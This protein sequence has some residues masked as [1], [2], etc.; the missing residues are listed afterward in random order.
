MSKENGFNYDDWLNAPREQ[1][2]IPQHARLV[3]DAGFSVFRSVIPEQVQ[4]VFA[5]AA[6]TLG[7]A[8]VE[9]FLRDGTHDKHPSAVMQ[10]NIGLTRKLSGKI[11]HVPLYELFD[12]LHGEVPSLQDPIETRIE[13]II[14]LR[15]S[16]KGTELGIIFDKSTNRRLQ[17][18]RRDIV[19]TINK[20]AGVDDSSINWKKRGRPHLSIV[21][22]RAKL[23]EEKI[24]RIRKSIRGPVRRK[25]I[26]LLPATLHDPSAHDDAK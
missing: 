24:E 13:S 23:A 25:H 19:R 4:P 6:Q 10:I 14:P 1:P 21:D 8:G 22:I 9:G 3:S 15:T 20:L 11:G 18:E 5:S 26:T 7:K 17:Q 12:E 16:F 2:P